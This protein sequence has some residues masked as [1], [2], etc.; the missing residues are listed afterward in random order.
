MIGPSI[1][2]TKGGI[3][4]VIQGY[5]QSNATQNG[6]VIKHLV[7]HVEGSMFEKMTYVLKSLFTF[8]R[9]RNVS[10]VHIH[11]ASD[12]SFYRKSIFVLLSRW[13]KIPVA[14]HV[15]G[16][17]F[18]SFYEKS[19]PL[20]KRYIA[21]VFRNTSSVIVL[22]DFWRNFFVKSFDLQNIKV[23]YNAVDCDAFE[24]CDTKQ[25]FMGHFLFLGRLGERKGIYDLVKAIDILV[26]RNK[27]KELHF[28]FAGDG[29]VDEVKN[30][31]E[32]LGLSNHIDILGWVD[33]EAKF[34]VLKQADTVIL[35]SYN[36]GLPVALLEAMAAG[37]IVLS[38]TVGGIPDL[39]ENDINGYL[40]TPGDVISLAKKI[41]EISSN[42]IRM[43]AISENNIKK[44]KL[45]F[46]S[47]TI[48]EDLFQ[49]YRTIA[50]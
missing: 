39:V 45:H 16:A 19:R 32:K 20:Q 14:M 38:T 11:T 13:R 15:H 10:I 40:I 5:L 22:S 17:D 7:S 49:L 35:P 2:R 3:A 43:A 33:V 46:N 9:L 44:I 31:V 24:K 12:A 50:V 29:E 21:Y 8:L 42:K 36:E 28:I 41:E 30:E 34:E 23:L 25:E 1:E 26:N 4:S 37:K 6:F 18:D 27:Q 47:N 48:N